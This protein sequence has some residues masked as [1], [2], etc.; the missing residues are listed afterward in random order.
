MRS[1]GLLVNISIASGFFIVSEVMTILRKA[2]LMFSQLGARYSSV[3]WASGHLDISPVL[4]A[5][6]HLDIS[7]I[8]LDSFFALY[9][10]FACS[11]GLYEGAN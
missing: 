6:G 10:C 8:C 5:S 9:R 1:V 3:L 4:W 11:K 7:P 2:P